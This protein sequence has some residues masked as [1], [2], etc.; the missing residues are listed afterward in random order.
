MDINKSVKKIQKRIAER[1]A[2]LKRLNKKFKRVSANRES[3]TATSHKYQIAAREE[4]LLHNEIVELQEQNIEDEEKITEL[5][6]EY[7]DELKYK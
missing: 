3:L 1:N 4:L 2:S 7:R 6:E 5:M